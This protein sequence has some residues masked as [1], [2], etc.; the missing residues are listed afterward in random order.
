MTPTRHVTQDGRGERDAVRWRG[1]PHLAVATRLAHLAGMEVEF[2]RD[3]S[4]RTKAERGFG[5]TMPPACSSAGRSPSGTIAATTARS[6]W[7]RSGISTGSPTRWSTRT[8]M[9]S[10]ASSPPTW[11][12][13]KR[14]AYGD[15][16]NDPER[17]RGFDGGLRGARRR[18]HRGHDRGRHRTVE[19]RGRLRSG[20]HHGGPATRLLAGRDPRARRPHTGGDRRAAPRVREDVAELG[21]RP[22]LAR[23][24]RAGAARHR[25][26]RSGAGL[27]GALGT[28]PRPVAAIEPVAVV[29][30]FASTARAVGDM[31]REVAA[32]VRTV[33]GK[34]A[35]SR[36]RV[37]VR[38]VAGPGMDTITA[39]RRAAAGV[40]DG[41]VREH[42]DVV[43]SDGTP[44]S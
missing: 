4:D 8:A 20:Q 22:H 30:M 9:A 40:P 36:G 17:H 7:S 37:R 6:A 13:D 33:V 10:V 34:R 26:G 15:R 5:S 32:T 28:G 35:A 19:R 41:E 38:L 1:R 29:A 24:R 12:A 3:K 14:G 16:P 21:A 39:D 27:L 11:P 42:V 31:R 25:G 43:G 2:D 23:P 44:R 18:A